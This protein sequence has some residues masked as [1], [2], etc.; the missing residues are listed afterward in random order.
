[1]FKFNFG[2]RAPKATPSAS[3]ST[4]TSASTAA[5]TERSK[6][7]G[8]VSGETI[9]TQGQETAGTTAPVSASAVAADA[10]ES[11]TAPVIPKEQSDILASLGTE[12]TKVKHEAKEFFPAQ[13]GLFQ[14]SDLIS[15]ITKVSD[16]VAGVY[17]GGLKQWECSEDL[18]EFL[19]DSVRITRDGLDASELLLSLNESSSSSSSAATASSSSSSLASAAAVA[20]L[21][22]HK[23]TGTIAMGDPAGC[24]AVDL[25]CGHALPL[26]YLLFKGAGVCLFQDLN[27]EVLSTV[28]V[29]K[30]LS[31]VGTAA[32]VR[33]KTSLVAATG[34]AALF[35]AL[36][37]APSADPSVALP[38]ST[39]TASSSSS[40]SSASSASPAS[41]STEEP[42]V[43]QSAQAAGDAA[44][45][46]KN[47][48]DQLQKNKGGVVDESDESED[49]GK[50]SDEVV[51][52]TAAPSAVEPLSREEKIAKLKALWQRQD[53]QVASAQ[54]VS[55]ST[56][57]MVQYEQMKA[58]VLED[59]D[60]EEDVVDLV[61]SVEAEDGEEEEAAQPHQQQGEGEEEEET[62]AIPNKSLLSTSTASSAAPAAAASKAWALETACN[63]MVPS[64]SSSSSSST[65]STSSAPSYAY[66]RKPHA[67]F[68]SGAW[69]DPE[70][71]RLMLEAHCGP[72]PASTAPST[73]T[74]EDV[75][76]SAASSR[77]GPTTSTATEGV[78][79]HVV[80]ADA[81]ATSSSAAQARATLSKAIA[82]VA[83]L[84]EGPQAVLAVA[85]ESVTPMLASVESL[86]GA[87]TADCNTSG[88][89]NHGVVVLVAEAEANK[90]GERQ[91]QQQQ[92]QCEETSSAL[93]SSSADSDVRR[94]VGVTLMDAVTGSV[95]WTAACL[96]SL[97][98]ADTTATTPVPA[99]PTV[100]ALLDRAGEVALRIITAAAIPS[101]VDIPASTLVRQCALVVPA[102]VPAFHASGFQEYGWRGPTIKDGPCF[103]SMARSLSSAAPASTSSAQSA[104]SA[105]SSSSS[106]V[107]PKDAGSEP[108]SSSLRYDYVLSADTLYFV[109]SV[110]VL[111]KTIRSVLHERG[112]ALI[113]AKR[114]YFGVGGSTADF[115]SKI[116][117]YR[118]MECTVV[119]VIKDG[120]SN[121][122]EILQVKW[123]LPQPTSATTTSSPGSAAS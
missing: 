83:A 107:V 46:G 39:P 24:R 43:S 1:M 72:A 85:P 33:K 63:L 25:G 104:S 58:M 52:S 81:L 13:Q 70:L 50:E 121:I 22:V 48:Q 118:D 6:N 11:K 122:R 49:Q 47:K 27:E 40:A 115:R 17:E 56:K 41:K 92:L 101:P 59:P 71:T 79:V 74:V 89:G 28:T 42:T 37:P 120:L 12:G 76:G 51:S 113:A 110:P 123:K 80:D 45:T 105:T 55:T 7:E 15:K 18:L 93:L 116:A 69:G 99:A 114:Y 111:I 53:S 35:S 112:V 61:L 26:L 98:S 82:Y 73:A 21:D 108:L 106:L 54:R 87:V 10:V 84:R 23:A 30:V 3:S 91:Q 67:Q 20:S 19:K 64:S 90:E 68:V 2:A 29:P 5:T 65:S 96:I 60:V 16:V 9:K 94:V 103:V 38:I 97:P 66:L 95:T 31:L 100:R 88:S 32:I 102:L 36:K 117:A 4:S 86:E 119:R 78:L 75:D 34:P 109:D 8:G 62:K 57:D 44:N 14:S 77:L